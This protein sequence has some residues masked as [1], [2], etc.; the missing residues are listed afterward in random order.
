MKSCTSLGRDGVV[1]RVGRGH[2]ADEDEHD[3]AH[4]LL[5]VVGAVEEADA[6]AGENQQRADGPRRRRVVLGRLVEGRI[7]DE[8]LGKQ[9]QQRGRANPTMRRN[10]QDLEDLGG[11]L[12]V[13]ARGAAVQVHELVGDADADDGADHGVR[14]RCRQAEPPGAEVPENGGDQQREDHGEAGAG[15]DLENEFD[16]QQRDDR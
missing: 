1:E 2:R 3:Q 14:A 5:A 6:G 4:A 13:H 9:E 15:A 10:E 16:R 11:L 7:F 8:P 12:P